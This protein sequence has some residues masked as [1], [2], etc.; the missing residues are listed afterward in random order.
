MKE[1]QN[2]KELKRLSN[3][4]VVFTPYAFKQKKK[5]LDKALK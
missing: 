5:E 2:N 4:F 1:F 3:G